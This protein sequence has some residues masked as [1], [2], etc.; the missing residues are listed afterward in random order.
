MCPFGL[1]SRKISTPLFL[2]GNIKLDEMPN[3]KLKIPAYLTLYFK[4]LEGTS[5]KNYKMQLPVLLFL[6]LHLFLYQQMS[7][8]YI[9][10]FHSTLSEKDF[11]CKFSFLNRFTQSPLIAKICQ[12]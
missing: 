1:L 7:F 9:L 10:E 5:V 8:F 2:T 11:C 6:V 4:F 3:I 12:A